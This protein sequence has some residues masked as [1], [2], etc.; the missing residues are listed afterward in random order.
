MKRLRNIAS[1][2]LTARLTRR[3]LTIVAVSFLL[4]LVIL[5][6]QYLT[7]RD[8]L[9]DRALEAQAADVASYI[10]IAAGGHPLVSLPEALEEGYSHPD[11]QYVYLIVD[12]RDG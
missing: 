3:V 4:L 10:S 5:K 12:D 6:V 11:R 9:R 7:E 2:S 1:P 8:S